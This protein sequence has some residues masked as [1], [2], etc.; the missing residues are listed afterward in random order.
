MH[1][2]A[3]PVDPADGLPELPEGAAAL[4]GAVLGA[5]DAGLDDV[6]VLLDGLAELF[7]LLLH[8]VIASATASVTPMVAMPCTV[9]F[10]TPPVS[11]R[12]G[13]NP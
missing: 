7:G 8:A 11:F 12:D 9:F 10:T 13:S 2:F 6:G 5:L 3:A 4:D 1:S